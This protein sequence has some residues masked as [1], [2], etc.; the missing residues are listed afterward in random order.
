MSAA[1]AAQVEAERIAQQQKDAAKRAHQAKVRDT[2]LVRDWE[3][4]QLMTLPE[5]KMQLH[6]WRQ[7]VGTKFPSLVKGAGKLDLA[8]GTAGKHAV[9][10]LHT[11]TAKEC[12]QLRLLWTLQKL[13]EL[14]PELQLSMPAVA[15]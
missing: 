2:A 10:E 7:Y 11:K 9:P 3:Q 14:E 15:L 12:C 4:V 5:L 6:A 8:V 1:I 13:H